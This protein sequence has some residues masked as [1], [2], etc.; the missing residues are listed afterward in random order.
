MTETKTSII[1]L[2]YVKNTT[3][4]K[5]AQYFFCWLFIFVFVYLFISQKSATPITKIVQQKKHYTVNLKLPQNCAN[6]YSTFQSSE[7]VSI[8]FYQ[9]YIKCFSKVKIKVPIL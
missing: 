8:I 2:D 3:V 1:E 6:S 4:W 5:N 7:N 9:S